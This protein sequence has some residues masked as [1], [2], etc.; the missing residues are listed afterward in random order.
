VG[1]N[2]SWHGNEA[3][4]INLLD[5]GIG[6]TTDRNDPTALNSDVGPTTWK[7]RTIDDDRTTHDTIQQCPPPF[8]CDGS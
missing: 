5:P 3:I 4:S 6:D 1:V 7:A 8:K 2:N